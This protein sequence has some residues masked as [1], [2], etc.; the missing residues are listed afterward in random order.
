MEYIYTTL[1][2]LPLLCLYTLLRR[3]GW[4]SQP[5]RVLLASSVAVGLAMC[6]PLQNIEYA[7]WPRLDAPS[8][9][10]A[11]YVLAAVPY[12]YVV[13]ALFVLQLHALRLV[14][15]ESA[16]TGFR[17]LLDDVAQLGRRR[18]PGGRSTAAHASH[19]REAA[20]RSITR[21]AEVR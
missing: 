7:L 12:L 6:L 8:P 14:T 4:R 20:A 19:H 17:N 5:Y 10:V 21:E 1:L 9:A 15:G 2:L 13:L 3:V 16:G 11:A 18:G